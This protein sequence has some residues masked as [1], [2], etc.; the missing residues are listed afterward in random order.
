MPRSTYTVY[1][2]AVYYNYGFSYV[3]TSFVNAVTATGTT[4]KYIQGYTD[5]SITFSIGDL[6]LSSDARIIQISLQWSWYIYERYFDT[7]TYSR[8]FIEIG[9][10]QYD[11]G[12]GGGIIYEWY[13][14]SYTIN[15]WWTPSQF[16]DARVGWIS[17]FSG[18]GYLN[19]YIKVNSAKVVVTVLTPVGVMRLRGNATTFRLPLYNIS[20]LPSTETALRIRLP[21]SNA[22]FRLVAT[23]DASSSPL[24]IKVSSGVK[25]I[26][27]L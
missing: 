15:G 22:C 2:N 9:G 12:W 23:S 3:D 8:A 10:V 13:S 11:P 16:N 19:S 4:S 21:S 17:S 1:P 14:T 6:S 7:S 26:A 25:A 27:K 18:P 24:R 20:D 5:E